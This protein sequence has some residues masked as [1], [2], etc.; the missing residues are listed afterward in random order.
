MVCGTGKQRN[1]S[2]RNTRELEEDL[3]E[4]MERRDSER[5]NQS[6]SRSMNGKGELGRLGGVTGGVCVG[7]AGNASRSARL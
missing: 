5:S 1:A 2:K 6:P 3:E 4:A 7:G